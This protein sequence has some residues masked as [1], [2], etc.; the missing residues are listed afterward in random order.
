MKKTREE[1][2]AEIKNLKAELTCA[3][4]NNHQRNLELDAL[5]YVWCNGGCEG[6]T[7]FWSENKI[8]EDIVLAADRNTQR[9]I[10]W[11]INYLFR[12]LPWD[13]RMSCFKPDGPTNGITWQEKI[14][15]FKQKL[16][17][18]NIKYD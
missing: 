2:E 6:G 15:L 10:S 13:F 9:M 5:H 11:Y 17:E 16:D 12:R 1:L 4:Q 3:Y 7:H 14:K 18:E 8:T